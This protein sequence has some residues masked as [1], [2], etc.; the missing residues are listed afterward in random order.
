MIGLDKH[1]TFFSAVASAVVCFLSSRTASLDHVTSWSVFLPFP[2]AAVANEFLHLAHRDD[3]TITPLKM[4]SSCILPMAGIWRSRVAR[5]CRS[6]FKP[7]GVGLLLVHSISSLRNVDPTRFA[8]PHLSSR[9]G[10][11]FLLNWTGK[12]VPK[13]LQQRDK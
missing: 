11:I 9:K 2:A 6:P 1:A 7:G 5:Y 3:R 4:Q 8:F 10:A 13:M 12:D